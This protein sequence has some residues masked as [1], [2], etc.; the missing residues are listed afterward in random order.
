MF[1]RDLSVER[2]E[3]TFLQSTAIYWQDN[4]SDFVGEIKQRPS[5]KRRVF[6]TLT[7][8]KDIFGMPF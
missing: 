8:W 4:E 2:C 1:V 7:V 3:L 5:Q 6:S